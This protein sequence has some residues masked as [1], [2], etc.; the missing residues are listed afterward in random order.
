MSTTVLK[1]TSTVLAIKQND[2]ALNSTTVSVL[3]YHYPV[4]DAPIAVADQITVAEGATAGQPWLSGAVSVLAND[5][6]AENNT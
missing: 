4:N 2:G 1:T 6:D 3:Y 5:T